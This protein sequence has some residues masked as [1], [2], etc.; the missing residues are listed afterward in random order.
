MVPSRLDEAMMQENEQLKEKVHM[1]AE[2]PLVPA[3]SPGLVEAVMCSRW[4]GPER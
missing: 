3:W 4:C 1:H 2:Q